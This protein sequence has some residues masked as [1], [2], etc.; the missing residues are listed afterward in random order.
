MTTQNEQ[1]QHELQAFLEHDI[2]TARQREVL[3]AYIEHGSYRAA[4]GALGINASAV[5]KAV[6]SLRK[7]GAVQGLAPELGWNHP[8]PKP[9]FMRG[10]TVN[11]NADGSVKQTWEKSWVKASD[12]ETAVREFCGA[13]AEA[14]AGTSRAVPRAE[15]QGDSDEL[16]TVYPLGDPHLGM[17]AWAEECG[18]DFD[19]EI[20]R[21]DLRSALQRL[22]G[23]S[24][25]S[26]TA[27]LLNLGD[28]FHTDDA[29]NTTRRSGNTLDVDTRWARVLRLGAYLMVDLVEMLLH[30]HYEVI[31]RNVIGNH[32]DHSAI[33]LALI[34]DAY[35]QNNERVQVDLSPAQVW[36]YQHGK[37]MLAA[38][39]GHATKKAD[40]PGVMAADQ[41]KMWGETEFRYG[42]TGHI[43]HDSEQ[44]RWGVITR[45]YRTLAA[46]DAYTAG[47]GYR[48]GRDMK[49]HVLHRMYGEIMTHR[50][51]IVRVKE[52]QRA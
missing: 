44:E 11:R 47:A 20:A 12:F 30:K 2:G 50:V 26:E 45:S 6:S 51:D 28:F 21:R 27:I 33:A 4:A 10:V 48:S 7:Q 8:V 34:L 5:Y 36:Y 41:P 43:H 15:K 1:E 46:R 40:L 52:D 49:C 18:E 32:D 38:T 19:V 24:P 16:L 39:H 9:H 13:L 3:A 42:Y 35:Y 37:C 17:Y 23:S 31:V 25:P 22:V 14:T 29:S